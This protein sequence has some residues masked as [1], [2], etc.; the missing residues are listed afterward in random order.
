MATKV[1]LGI[2]LCLFAFESVVSTH[3]APER[4]WFREEAQQ[5]RLDRIQ[6]RPPSRRIEWEG[7]ITEVWDEANEEFQCAG[8]AA[9][10]NIIRPNSLSLPKFHSSPMLAYIERGIK[11][12]IVFT[13]QTHYFKLYFD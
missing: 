10:R 8:V 4:H 12:L 9:F 11:L 1:V 6:A 5:C 13:F 3:H 7:G 2:L